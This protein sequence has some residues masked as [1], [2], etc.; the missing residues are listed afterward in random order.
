MKIRTDF[1]TNSSSSS[2]IFKEDVYDRITKSIE[3]GEEFQE[4][5][6]KDIFFGK[7]DYE[8]A[9]GSYYNLVYDRIEK[10]PT[11][12][13]LEV[14]EWYYMDE[15]L[16]KSV[17]SVLEEAAKKNDYENIPE[18]ILHKIACTFV[19]EYLGAFIDRWSDEFND[20]LTHDLLEN[21]ITRINENGGYD[22]NKYLAFFPFD[23]EE[24]AR[25]KE[26]I[27]YVERVFF[28]HHG[29]ILGYIMQMEGRSVGSLLEEIVEAKYMYY[30]GSECYVGNYLM[31]FDGC[32][33]G[34]SHMG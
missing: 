16:G 8:L 12:A 28:A 34:C 30:D 21:I 26:F 9:T 5:L 14:Y 11:Y 13:I 29:M 22:I 25:E 7:D 4:W 3:E 23:D 20:I 15:L 24:S 31:D 17:I 1:V 2:F 19:L 33:L 18:D 10:F 6:E 27:E 32:V